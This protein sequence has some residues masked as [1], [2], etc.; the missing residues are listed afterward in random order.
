MTRAGSALAAVLAFAGLLA[1][2]S[3]EAGGEP[4][5]GPDDR[6]FGPAPD[7]EEH[8]TSLLT[9]SSEEDIGTVCA[10][11][12][13]ALHDHGY[14]IWTRAGGEPGGDWCS[15]VVRHPMQGES[16]TRFASGLGAAVPTRVHAWSDDEASKV[17]YFDPAPLFAAAGTSAALEDS[18]DDLAAYGRILAADLEAVASE[19]TGGSSPERGAPGVAAYTEV[20]AEAPAEALAEALPEAAAEG[21]LRLIDEI[22][23]EDGRTGTTFVF[24][25]EGRDSALYEGLFE[26]S[27]AIGAANPV[28]L[29]LWEDDSGN[30][31]IS[32]FD[33]MPLF[34]AVSPEFAEA[35]AE[36][37]TLVSEAV[38][39]AALP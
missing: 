34:G 2:C 39:A 32:Y 14:L 26:T 6:P 28:H 36:A 16:F 27:A 21:G 13:T 7:Y 31:V 19:A 8:T 1:G 15:F 30:G 18:G 4:P 25:V 33:P 10:D 9:A 5:P 22:V 35:G 24:A 23:Y 29:H 38:W 20:A 37:S 11:L 17:G 3:P 12:E